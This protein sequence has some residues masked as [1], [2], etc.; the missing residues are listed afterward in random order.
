LK[1][2]E[3]IEKAKKK[4]NARVASQAGFRVVRAGEVPCGRIASAFSDVP[5]GLMLLRN[6]LT[7]GE[8]AHGPA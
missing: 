4:E 7:S 5:L 3:D 8:T 6:L 2:N 1:V